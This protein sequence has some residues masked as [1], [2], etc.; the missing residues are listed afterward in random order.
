MMDDGMRI[1][2]FIVSY[3]HFIIFK[4]MKHYLFFAFQ[5]CENRHGYGVPIFGSGFV[6]TQHLFKVPGKSRVLCWRTH[7]ILT[8]TSWMPQRIKKGHLSYLNL[9]HQKETQEDCRNTCGWFCHHRALHEIFHL[10]LALALEV[11]STQVYP[12]I[13]IF[14]SL[15]NSSATMGLWHRTNWDICIL[16][17]AI[18]CEMKSK[19]KSFDVVRRK[20]VPWK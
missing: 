2:A 7:Y 11:Y 3:D 5:D 6:S 19:E 20:K 13:H 15:N 1:Q 12:G 16:Y 9:Q 8:E 14:M 10:F 17:F 18:F 4:T